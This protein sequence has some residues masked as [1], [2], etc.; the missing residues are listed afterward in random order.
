MQKVKTATKQKYFS[1]GPSF[2]VFK[3]RKLCLNTE[4]KHAL[5]LFEIRGQ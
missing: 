4:T 2:S 1:L 5:I 3:H